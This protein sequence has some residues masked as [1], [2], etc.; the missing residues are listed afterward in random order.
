[1]KDEIAAHTKG[2]YKQTCDQICKNYH[3]QSKHQQL[4]IYLSKIVSFWVPDVEAFW[5]GCEVSQQ[6]TIGKILEI[7]VFAR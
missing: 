1:M 2:K 4:R 7:S 6:D 5:A 3:T